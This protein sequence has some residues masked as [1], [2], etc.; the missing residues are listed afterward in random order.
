MKN[1]VLFGFMGTGKTLIAKIMEERKGLRRVDMDDIIEQREGKTISRIFS[2]DGESYFRNCEQKIAVELGKKSDL[3]ISTGGGVVLNKSNIINLSKNG[4]CVCLNAT[5]E[6]VYNRVKHETH[7]PLLQ[8]GDPMTTIREML[9][10]RKIFYDAVPFQVVTD[11]KT[12]DI[13]CDE[14]EKIYSENQ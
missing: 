6:T 2:E 9:A 10:N 11:N 4:V 13:I 1:I 7:R 12:P 3:I 8:N 5:P 14:I